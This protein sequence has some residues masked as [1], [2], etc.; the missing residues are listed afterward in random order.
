MMCDTD[1]LA[2]EEQKREIELNGRFQIGELMAAGRHRE[3]HA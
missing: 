1:D 2:I 3:H